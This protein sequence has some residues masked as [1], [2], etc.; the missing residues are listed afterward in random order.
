[1]FVNVPDQ[2]DARRLLGCWTSSIFVRTSVNL[3]RRGIIAL[4]CLISHACDV[5]IGGR[6]NVR[7]RRVVT[8][9][10]VRSRAGSLEVC[11]FIAPV[12]AES[13]V[14]G[15]CYDYSVIIRYLLVIQA[16]IEMKI[17]K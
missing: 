13:P 11:S 9:Q 4:F 3:N 5:H 12:Y 2:I 1:L 7:R 6:E 14:A 16:F 8:F 15:K 10:S 17:N